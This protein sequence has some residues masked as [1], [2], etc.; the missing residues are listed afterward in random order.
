MWHV[1]CSTLSDNLGGQMR[2][3]L[4]FVT[5]QDKDF[6]EGLPYAS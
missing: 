1:S 2:K 6:D 3:Q 5:Y 4:L